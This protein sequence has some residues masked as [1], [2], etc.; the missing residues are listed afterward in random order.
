MHWYGAFGGMRPIAGC[1]RRNHQCGAKQFIAQID[2]QHVQEIHLAGFDQAGEILVDTHGAR[3]CD[4][5]WELYD[6]LTT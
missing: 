3:V 4:A 5:A 2:A 6:Y 1:E